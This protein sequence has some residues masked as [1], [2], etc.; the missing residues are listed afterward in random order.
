MLNKIEP[1]EIL[2]EVPHFE[3][4]AYS[5]SRGV[6]SW[7]LNGGKSR[8]Q[9]VDFL[10]GIWLGHPLHSVLTDMTIGALTF[11]FFLDP[12]VRLVER[13]ASEATRLIRD[14]ISARL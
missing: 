6:H 9:V 11:S 14:R 12:Q 4:Q 1:E 7:V 10:H 3:E 13:S 2:R 8:R 5:L